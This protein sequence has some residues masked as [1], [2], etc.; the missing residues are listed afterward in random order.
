MEQSFR[1]RKA[2]KHQGMAFTAFFLAAVAAYSSLLFLNDPAKHGFKGEHSIA[3]MVGL[4]WAVFGSMLLISIYIWST[5]YVEQITIDGTMIR[6]RSMFQRQEFDVTELQ[7]VKWRAHPIGGSILFRVLGAKARVDLNG[8]HKDDRLR[9]IRVLR[10]LVPPHMQEGWPMF[11]HKVA[12]PL[13]DGEPPI[14][15]AEPSAEL[16]TITR[17][18]YDRALAVAFPLSVAAAV[19]LSVWFGFW[20][21]LVLPFFVIAGWFLLRFSVPVAG[22]VELRLTSTF[23]PSAQLIGLAAAFGSLVLVAAL[24]LAGVEPSVACG[25]GCVVMLVT[26]PPCLYSLYRSDKERQRAHEQTAESA[27]AQWEQG[28]DGAKSAASH[29]DTP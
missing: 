22:Y 9:M 17:K 29:A 19:L 4:G 13:R 12:L 20:H 3:I 21:F 11:C 24:R 28:E 16:V 26:F 15:R 10:D 7:S 14:L 2:I 5:Y 23:R 27:P 18:R 6:I 25:I 1:L 8:F